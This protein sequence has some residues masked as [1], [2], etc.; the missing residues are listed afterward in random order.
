MPR[1]SSMQIGASFGYLTVLRESKRRLG[2]AVMWDC[3]CICGK[4]YAVAGVHLR[5]GRTQSCGCKK[6]KPFEESFPREMYSI[7]KSNAVNDRGLSFELPFGCFV[8]MLQSRCAYCGAPPRN[9]RV[10]KGRFQRGAT[11]RWNG[12]DR[13]DSAQGYSVANC[14]ACCK[15]CNRAK[16]AMS[17]VEYKRWITEARSNAMNNETENLSTNE[18]DTFSLALREAVRTGKVTRSKDD[19]GR[20]VYTVVPTN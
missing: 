20:D 12:I 3:R 7:Y 15:V 2:S 5:S 16:M 6:A 17:A 1:K 4:E 13:V 9:E 11:Y 19:E 10:C 8:K 14:V 18:D